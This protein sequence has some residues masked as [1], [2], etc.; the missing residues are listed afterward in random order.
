M[1]RWLLPAAFVF[2][3]VLT[4]YVVA[5]WNFARSCADV[6]TVAVQ[7][8]ENM[9][10]FRDHPFDSSISSRLEE[11]KR[12]YVRELARCREAFLVR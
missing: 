1:K 2:A 11:L 10:P 9:R 6:Q 3:G 4:G 7:F 5:G 12:D 8:K